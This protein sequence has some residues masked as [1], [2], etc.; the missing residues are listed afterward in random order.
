MKSVREDA[1][2]I[3]TCS[4]LSSGYGH[5]Q[6]RGHRLFRL[7]LPL[8]ASSGDVAAFQAYLTNLICTTLGSKST[9]G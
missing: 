4:G 8:R 9:L 3:N 1:W 6:L 7:D 2:W 5:R